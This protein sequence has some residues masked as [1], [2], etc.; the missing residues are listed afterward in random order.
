MPMDVG[1]LIK[2]ARERHGISQES[3]ALRAGTDQAA[4][5]RIE[6]GKIS[7]N[8]DTVDRLLEAMGERLRVDVERIP[9]DHDPVHHRE[10]LSR[11]LEE[12]LELA[13]SWNR[14]ASQL[15]EAGRSAR[16]G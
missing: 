6:G 2:Q 15:S 9:G 7:P 10:L 14:L 16:A 13:I 12:R 5:S 8:V 4:V 3:L 11:S 1:E